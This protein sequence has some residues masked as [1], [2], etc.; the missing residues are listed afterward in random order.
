MS[1][2][3]IIFHIRQL[4]PGFRLKIK[5]VAVILHIEAT[6][7]KYLIAINV[8]KFVLICGERQVNVW[9]WKVFGDHVEKFGGVKL[10]TAIPP[11]IIAA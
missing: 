6:T 9:L 11:A 8:D 4:C 3:V 1:T 5:D 2:T 7:E 10:L